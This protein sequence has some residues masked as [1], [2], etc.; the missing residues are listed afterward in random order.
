MDGAA[1]YVR[2]KESLD[3]MLQGVK[4]LAESALQDMASALGE[5][6]GGIMAGVSSTKDLGKVLLKQLSGVLGQL[7]QLAIKAG[8]TMLG[9]QEMFKKGLAGGPATAALA[10]GAGIA[11]VALSKY[12][13]SKIDGMGGGDEPNNGKGIPALANGGIVS[14]P[15]LSLIGEA[16]PE[17]V[18]P[19][20]KMNNMFNGSNN[21]SLNVSFPMDRMVIALDR[22]RRRNSRVQ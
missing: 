11:L 13:A 2:I 8:V 18:I 21:E 9:L 5:G 6:I 12:T 17:A 1:V 10:I 3:Q 20:S 15:T 19:L 14:A 7:G 4:D 16:G 22:Q